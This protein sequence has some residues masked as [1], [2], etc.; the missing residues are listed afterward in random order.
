LAVTLQ[1]TAALQPFVEIG[2]IGGVARRQ[3]RVD[4][5]DAVAELDA[6]RLS[7][8][9]YAW[10]AADQQRRAQ[11]LL[12]ERCRCANHL[13]LLAFGEDDAARLPVQT[14]EH[15]LQDAGD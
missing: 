13:L 10:L 11:P 5:L 3:R 4:D 7:R 12:L 6:E 9:A 1:E 14:F 2:G 8:L 15:P